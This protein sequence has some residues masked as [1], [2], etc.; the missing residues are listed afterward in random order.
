MEA[1][2]V[3]SGRIVGWSGGGGGLAE[4]EGVALSLWSLGRSGWER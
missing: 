4:S 2:R 3:G 1:A